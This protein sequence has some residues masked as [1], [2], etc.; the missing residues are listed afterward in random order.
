MIDC[1]S[2][3]L[4]TSCRKSNIHAVVSIYYWHICAHILLNTLL[5]LIY[6]NFINS[7]WSWLIVNS[8]VNEKRIKNQI[9]FIEYS[10]QNI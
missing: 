6:L 9:Y 10:T 3:D 1:S 5:L 7:E 4:I 2:S 8:C